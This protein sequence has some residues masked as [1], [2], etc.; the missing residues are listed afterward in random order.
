MVVSD[1]NGDLSFKDEPSGGGGISGLT[2]GR[3]TL[4][5][6]STSIGD[7]ADLLFD[8]S[9]LS[10]STTNTQGQLNVGGNKNLSSSGAQQ[11]NAAAT[12]TDNT[13]AASGTANSYSINLFSQPTIAA[14]NSSV[15]FPSIT[16]L[17][18]NAP[19]A[20]TNATITNPYAFQTG[21]NGHARIQGKLFLPTRDSSASPANIAWVDPVTEQLKVGP[22]Q[23]TLKGTKNWT[24][25]SV[26]AG[27]STSTTLTVTGAAVGDPVSVCKLGGYSNG[28]IY[29]AFVS[30][31]NTVTIRVHNVSTGSANYS[32]AAD[33]NVVVHKY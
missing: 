6:G 21:T 22:Y 28:E 11:Y 26:S 15:T 14:T 5:T 31:T 29:D 7:D 27:S 2:S 4:S 20:G 23:Q 10:V 25:G 12:Y 24:P 8:G 3:V 9:S 1:A 32:S 30:A 33:Y 16:T 19:T 18:V 17:F 13:T